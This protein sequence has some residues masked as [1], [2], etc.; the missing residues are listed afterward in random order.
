MNK[1]IFELPVYRLSEKEYFS[2]QESR[3][4]KHYKE[5]FTKNGRVKSLVS[6]EDYFEKALR[7]DDIWKYNEIIGYIRLYFSGHQIRGEYYQHNVIHI[8][9]TRKKHFAYK[10]HKLAPEINILKMSDE[11]IYTSI[12]NYI[13][14][15]GIELENRYIDA[16]SFRQIGKY[17]QW[18]YLIQ[19]KYNNALEP[20]KNPR[21]TF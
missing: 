2:E 14:S 12:I 11:E 3:Y 5:V 17:V 20:I 7:F 13:D 18:N 10:T 16:D 21:A 15:C 8:R 9:K 4:K 6:F 19:G 1:Y